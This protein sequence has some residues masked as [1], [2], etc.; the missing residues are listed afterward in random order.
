MIFLT[1]IKNP[2]TPGADLFLL[3]SVKTALKISGLLIPSLSHD[4]VLITTSGF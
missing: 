3:K 2:P 4:S 1:Q